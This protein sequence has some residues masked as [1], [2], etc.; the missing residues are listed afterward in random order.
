MQEILIVVVLIVVAVVAGRMILKSRGGEETA[1]EPPRRADRTPKE[2]R[3]E[4]MGPGGVL[5][6]RGYGPDMSDIDVRV[7]SR[8][9]Y[10]Q[11]G[12]E[13]FELE[14]ES[15][16]GKVWLT[17]EEDDETEVTAS[18]R[19]LTL[20]EAGLSPERLKQFDD[21]EMG[22]FE[23][24][25]QTFTYTESDQA[26]FF[27]DGDR[28]KPQTFYYWEFSGADGQTSISVERW[29]TN[30]YEVHVSKAIDP[31][32]ITVYANTGEPST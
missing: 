16:L 21:D 20:A 3:I 2:V 11:E 5:S 25:G 9:L 23:F 19:R 28:L 13:W 14:G 22:Q 12:W 18:L 6:L 27:K 1:P 26:M 31:H 10:S 32:Q 4:N 29:G 8:H 17:V 24:E 15:E 7:L 30:E